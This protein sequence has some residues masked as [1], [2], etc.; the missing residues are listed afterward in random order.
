L[1]AGDEN[2]DNSI[3]A[4]DKIDW[5]S[6][7]GNRG[8]LSSDFDLDSQADNIDKNSKWISNMGETSQ[9]PE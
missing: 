1:F 3:N 6:Q 7:A 2:A 4:F 9:V 5:I 8:Y